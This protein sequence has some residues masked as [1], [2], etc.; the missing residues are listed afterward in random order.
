MPVAILDI[1]V[2]NYRRYQKEAIMQASDTLC[3]MLNHPSPLKPHRQSFLHVEYRA[4][5]HAQ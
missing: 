3:A 2:L 5:Q 1:W 4:H